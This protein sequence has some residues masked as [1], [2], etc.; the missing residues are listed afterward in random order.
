MK[1][2]IFKSGTVSAWK[3]LIIP[4]ASAE[5]RIT[6]PVWFYLIEAGEKRYLFDTGAYLPDYEPDE[7]ADFI[8]SVSSEELAVNQLKKTG[9]TPADISGIILSHWHRDHSGGVPDFPGVPCF[10]RREEMEVKQWFANCDTANWVCP[11]G[12]YDLLGDGRIIL[13]PTPG[14]TAGHQSLILTMDDG[15]K[16]L[17]AADAAY[18]QAAAEAVFKKYIDAGVKVIAGHECTTVPD[19]MKFDFYIKGKQLCMQ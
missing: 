3:N 10:V 17:L 5:E 8:L 13:L 1:L 19:T 14:H 15:E 6:V 4:E 7:N 11:E 18:T 12:E 2:H 9:I 16:I